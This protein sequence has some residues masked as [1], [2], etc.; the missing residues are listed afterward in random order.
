[1]RN[2][3]RRIT[4]CKTMT[5][6][7]ICCTIVVCICVDACEHC[8]KAGLKSCAAPG[9]GDFSCTCIDGYE[10]SLCHIGN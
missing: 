3:D 5:E 10:G 2:T 9:G 6:I 1:V 4:L 8:N 7:I